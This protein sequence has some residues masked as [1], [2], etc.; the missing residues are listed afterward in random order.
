[1][2]AHDGPVTMDKFLI[3]KQELLSVKTIKVMPPPRMVPQATS[4]VMEEPAA[5][6]VAPSIS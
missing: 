3:K 1:M 5:A 6:A 4:G 2:V